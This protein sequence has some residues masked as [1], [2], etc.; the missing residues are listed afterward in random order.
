VES[1][2]AARDLL[3]SHSATG[4]DGARVE[5]S[6]WSSVI[7]SPRVS[8]TLLFQV[9]EWARLTAAYGARLAV[10]GPGWRGG[11]DERRRLNAACQWLWALDSAVRSAQRSEPLSADDVRLLHAIPAN[12]RPPRRVPVGTET[13]ADLCQGA[14]VSAE[15]IRHAT[16]VLVPDPVW[17][18]A[19]TASSL[20]QTAASATVI[21]HHCHVL[22]HS[23]AIRA[24][25][26]G[27]ADL[28]D[29]LLAATDAAA[30]A[31]SFWLR[32]AR[33]WYRITTDTRHGTTPAAA[34]MADL[35]LWTGRLAYSD[36]A[37]T[38]ALGPSQVTRAPESLAPEPDDV[39]GVV[40]AVHQACETLTRIAT[41]DHS[42]IL[43]AGRARRLLMPT[44]SLPDTYD[45]PRPFAPAL[46]DRIR[47]LLV[48]YT[49]AGAASTQLTI[50]VEPVAADVRAPSHLLTMA[51]A[52][53][54][55][56]TGHT[57]T[58][59]GQQPAEPPPPIHEF[60]GPVER[61]MHDLGVTST[62]ILDQAAAIDQ[63]SERLILQAAQTTEPQRAGAV[64]DTVDLSRSADTAELI[65]YALASG[66]PHATDRLRPPPPT[67]K[68]QA[69]PRPDRTASGFSHLRHDTRSAAEMPGF[70]RH[71]D[72]PAADAEAEP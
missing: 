15:R 16:R 37:W 3:T 65:N 43:G 47:D 19:L 1:L 59:D 8:Q 32:A 6:E 58:A 45:V 49:A 34:E 53:T 13:V 38:P 57:A 36:P 67:A 61:I 21:S 20:R 44:R 24:G 35:T 4:P 66:N 41:T 55:P 12:T 33:S 30:D 68:R 11:R 46:P 69:T 71:Q 72:R 31:R 52:A 27:A 25:Q 22:L 18:P 48:A 23:L 29:R 64:A 60:P 63:A 39:R 62:H 51:R 70:G 2:A 17:S 5:L 26:H 14:T 42:Q 9:G 10:S 56:G 54:R 50:A 28:S 40:S 7:T